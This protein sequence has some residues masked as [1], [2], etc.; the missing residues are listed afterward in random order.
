MLV[1]PYAIY[2]IPPKKE[3]IISDGKLLLTDR[4]PKQGLTLP[5]DVFLRSLAQDVGSRSIG[6][7]L[8]GTGSDGSRGIRDIHEAG[9]LIIAQSE[10][11]AKFDGM[12]KSAVKTGIVDLVLAPEEIGQTLAKYAQHPIAADLAAQ[13]EASTVDEHGMTKLVR[14]LREAY[15]IDFSLYKPSTVTRRVERRLLLHQAV[16][17]E[18]YVESLASD[19]AELNS[20][21]HDLL[22]GVTQFF[23]DPDAFAQLDHRVLPELLS[24][25]PPDEE[26]RIWVVGCAT[27]EEAYSLAILV[28]EHLTRT[29]RPLNVKIF[30]TD[31][32]QSSL[33]VASAGVYCESSLADV[34]PERL[35]RYFTRK[36]DR[37]TTLSRMPPSRDWI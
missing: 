12:P 13:A 36:G 20:L 2:L 27:G 6:L 4:D 32:H 24:K 25:V 31:V 26:I 8:S 14:L 15:G 34:S 33:D 21:Y 1:E 18:Q 11:T 29:N 9:G 5:I 28:H 17:F 7:I 37:H 16:D 30:A 19:P 10:D 3:M 22:I 23:R 35:K